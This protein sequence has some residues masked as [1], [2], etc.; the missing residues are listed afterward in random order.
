MTTIATDGKWV[1][2]DGLAID[3]GDMIVAREREKLARVPAGIVGATGDS[4]D[5]AA[6]KEWMRCEQAGDCPVQ[7]DRFSGVLVKPDGQIFTCGK[8]GRLI[9][10]EAPFAIGSGGGYAVAA[11]IAGKSALEAVQIA[12]RLDP[13]SGGHL[14]SLAVQE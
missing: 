7:N 11:M 3:P 9:R 14:T 13:F 8:S 5:I 10:I 12:C 1:V 4:D 6:W 2:A